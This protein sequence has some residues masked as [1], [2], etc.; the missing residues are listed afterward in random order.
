M[1]WCMA[2]YRNAYIQNG[3]VR[4]CCWYDKT[5][6]NNK[7]DSLSQA[8]DIF[9]SDEF[10]FVRKTPNG[11]ATCVMHEEQGGT[12]HRMLWNKREQ[13]NEVQ[14]E[15]LEIYMGN[16]CNLAC[17]TCNSY[18]S[19]K[20]IA[21]E[22][23]AF[24][25]SFT[26][27]QDEIDIELTYF[28]VKNLKRVKLHGGEVT[29]MPQHIK[30]LQQ[31]I[32]FGVAENITLVYVVNNTVDPTQFKDYWNKFKDIEFICSV[33]GVGKVSDYIRYHSNWSTLDTNISKAV[34]MGIKVSFNCVVSVLNVY[35][36]P[37]ILDWANGDILFRILTKPDWLSIDVLSNDNK[38]KTIQRL[39][40]Y[41]ELSHVVNALKTNQTDWNK[42]VKW[43]D[44][45]DSN[46]KDSFWNINAQFSSG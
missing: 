19:S 20:W 45:I 18:N 46:R 13:G 5:K 35:H 40:P 21:E 25:K 30:L 17:V 27:K 44:T 26:N 4:P 2:P 24:G 1:T 8:G 12:S 9:H 10:D 29:I 42:F 41:K 36:L 7:V 28:L 14:L 11:C 23:K 37:D 6:L 22:Q 38:H 34:D 3:V 33:D 43:I 16:L 32:D 31:L 39:E 15:S